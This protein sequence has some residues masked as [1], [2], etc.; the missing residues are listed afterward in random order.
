[1]YM[2]VIR[3]LQSLVTEI[4]ST[5]C[6]F[7]SKQLESDEPTE[8]LTEW[9]VEP[10]YFTSGR[11]H[12]YSSISLCRNCMDKLDEQTDNCSSCGKSKGAN[13]TPI[14]KRYESTSFPISSD[15][16]ECKKIV[17]NSVRYR[18]CRNCLP[19]LNYNVYS[20]CF[21]IAFSSFILYILSAFVQYT[22]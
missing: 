4:K 20:I 18:L 12:S 15:K 21:S 2:E 19:G 1:M 5:N 7:C 17:V 9:D 11:I 10:R 22:F 14:K 3:S 16:E 13:P 6:L 8:L